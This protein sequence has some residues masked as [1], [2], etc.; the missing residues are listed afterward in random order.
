MN[1]R[2]RRV[3]EVMWSIRR[4]GVSSA[5]GLIVVA[6]MAS[7]SSALWGQSTAQ[8]SGTVRDQSGAVLPGVEVGAT[9]TDTGLMRSAITNETGAYVLPNLPVGP[10]KVEASLPGF[11]TY[12]Q[13]GIVLQVGANTVINA[14]LEVGQVSETVEVQADAAMV[15]TRTT[16]IGQVIDNVRV[17]ELPLNARQVTELI[18][19]SGAAITGGA[20]ATNRNFPTQSIS[21]AGG[22]NNGLTYTLDGGTHNDPFN[23]LNLPLPFPDALQEFK[24][25][26]SAAPAQYGQHSAGAVNAVTKSGTNELHGAI[27]DFAR[28]AVFNARNAFALQRDGLKRNQFGGVV[29]GPIARNKIFF[30]GGYQGTIER[31]APSDLRSYV[32]T[33]RMI[34]G[35]WTAVAAPECNTGRQI[36][37]RA[38]FVNNRISPAAF[39]TP[40]L[41]MMK[42]LPAPIDECGLVRYGRRTN[43]DEHI[44][45]G[46]VDYTL[47]EKHSLFGRG[48]SA[49][50][51]TPRDY[52]GTNILTSSQADYRR[53]ADSYV[54]GDTYLIG[55]GTVSAFRATLLRTINIK[56]IDDLF[57]LT[58]I[59]VRGIFYEPSLPK[60]AGITVGGNGFAIHSD[61]GMPGHTNSTVFQFSEDISMIRGAHQLGFGT[62]FIH[63]LMNNKKSSPTRPRFTFG[64]TFTGMGLG[65]FMLGRVA[66]FGQG[67]PNSFYYRQN[68]IGLYA[69]DTWKA[70]PKLTVN[71]GLRWEP[72]MAPWNRAGRVLYFEQEWFDKG[73]HSTVYKNAPAGMLFPGDPGVPDSKSIGP[74][75]LLRFAPRLG[76]AFDPKGDG[77]MTIRAAYGLYTDYP[78]FY[79]YGGYSDQPPWGYEVEIT[80]P[81]GGFED[82][83]RGYPGGNPF[84]AFLNPNIEFPPSGTFVT[85]SKDLKMPYI[86]QWNFSVQRQLG[87]NW[88]LAANYLGSNVVHNLITSEGNPGIFL[89]LGPCAI[90]GVNYPTCST[91]GNTDARRKLSL[92]SPVEGEA[93]GN[94]VVADDGGTRSYNGLLLQV[95][96]RRA[97]GVTVQGN[98]TWA[99]CIEDGGATPQFQ[100]S[101]NHVKERRKDNR[102]NCDQDR[103][104]NLNMSTVYETPQFSNPAMRV[105][106]TGWKVSGIVRVL[107]GSFFHVTPGTDR[108]LTATSTTV[109]QRV[110]QVLADVYAPNRSVDRYLNAAAFAIPAL[111]TY[112]TMGRN[113]IQGPGTVRIDMGLTRTFQA[114]E[115]QSLEFRAEVFNVPN[116]VNPGATN[117]PV[118]ALNNANFGRILSAGDPRIMQIALKYVF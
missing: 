118:T 18:V 27:F 70:T 62:N 72:Y 11:R 86:N 4:L 59:G 108:A 79:Q 60:I 115:N 83:F 63:S 7:T 82:P 107:S 41:N 1:G 25:E 96:R 39:S 42:R 77:R 109:D 24:V 69:Q 105:L 91:T 45:V 76:L 113:S 47:S 38:P 103:R 64:T 30:F 48:Q 114:R 28:N 74:D 87:T 66:T 34:A 52:D 97:N 102:G 49:R 95:Q 73:I 29:G 22:L 90:A 101:G 44:F 12:A 58:D 93:Y 94:L 14:A 61:P 89:G 117:A 23:N 71:A 100:N 10:Y 46:K 53:R 88:L 98:Y 36:T 54:L 110:N 20:Q 78:H 9:Q 13:T 3:L 26:T 80:E 75:H 56:T 92:M 43:N 112:G 84:P 50:L 106:A 55:S 65:D 21:V 57:T 5:A 37:L 51:W 104:H 8:I 85:I 35:D 32:P 81:V 2:K 15:E 17:L 33:P 16:S 6:L 111:G 116:H 40:A 68:Y 31:S 19:L 67:N 99:H